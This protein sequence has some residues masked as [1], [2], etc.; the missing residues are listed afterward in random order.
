VIQL[1]HVQVAFGLAYPLNIVLAAYIYQLVRL[2]Y[3]A[4]TTVASAMP[5]CWASF[6]GAEAGSS[7]LTLGV[8]SLS[9]LHLPGCLVLCCA[10]L[11]LPTSAT[12]ESVRLSSPRDESSRGTSRIT[13]DHDVDVFQFVNSAWMMMRQA[14]CSAAKR[15]APRCY[16]NL[17]QARQSISP[18]ELQLTLQVGGI[19]SRR[20][21][22]N[23]MGPG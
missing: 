21:V 6:P 14:I 4:A 7:T 10:H 16:G 3:V 19:S 20:T 11:S 17:H 15:A 8:A 13:P 5:V 18:L 23:G 9:I 22:Q 12:S 1:V 2:D